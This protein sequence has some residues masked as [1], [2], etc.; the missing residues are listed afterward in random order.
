MSIQFKNRDD[1]FKTMVLAG[2]NQSTLSLEIGMSRSY[3]NSSL[4][5]NSI[6][7]STALKICKVLQKEFDEI[8]LI[9]MIT[10]VSNQS[11]SA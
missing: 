8:F 4:D 6:S 5:R 1:F 7:A 10:K 11:K 2:Y 3:I 9:S